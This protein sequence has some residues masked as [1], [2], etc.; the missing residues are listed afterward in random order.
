MIKHV[1]KLYAVAFTVLLYMGCNG[2]E[3]SS[4]DEGNWVEESDF[5]GATRSGAVSFVINDLAYVGTGYDGED[6]LNDFWRYDP[7]RN[8]WFRIADFPGNPRNAAVAFTAD[9][10]GYVG[11]GYDGNRELRDFWEY[12]P[13]VD[14]WRQIDD[15]PGAARF[16]AVAFT[17]NGRGYV[18]TGND[19]DNNLKDFYQYAPASDSWVQISSM[20]GSK[21]QGA[22]AFVI[23]DF[24]YT[25][26]GIHNGQY[27]EDFWRYNLTT[28]L[29]ERMNDLDDDDTGNTLVLREYA[30]AFSIGEYAY[31]SVG[32]RNSNVVDTWRYSP[33]EDEWEELT[34]FEGT[35]R[36][37]AAA[38]V[39][40]DMGFVCT[41]R[42]IND[43]FD[44]IWSFRPL[45]EFDDED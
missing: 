33:L 28:D 39:I 24:A 44:D 12:D 34:E 9:G 6:R 16:G 14:Q 40:A 27:Q 35:A 30:S 37:Q 38:F 22:F 20:G 11:S 2:V 21:R 43:R 17:L 25:G 10:K 42:N 4:P 29:W 32:K 7:S 1:K 13:A 36:E 3:S 26:G 45:E 15:L 8:S 31:L 41:G 23:G 19:G 18:G 5:E